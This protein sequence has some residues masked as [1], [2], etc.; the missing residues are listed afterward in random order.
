MKFPTQP[1]WRA[2]TALCIAAACLQPAAAE[3]DYAVSNSALEIA[4]PG[5]APSPPRPNSPLRGEFVIHNRS[6]FTVGYSARWGDADWQSFKIPPHYQ[7]RHWHNLDAKGQAPR[8]YL[9]FDN[10]A[11]DKQYTA[12]IYHMKFGRVGHS[13]ATGPVNQAIQYEF[14]AQGNLVDL[15]QR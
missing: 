11:N 10:Q 1:S 6:G 5:K 15:V 3:D 2:L 9:K 12:K 14:T 8:P 7:R 13:P 4:T